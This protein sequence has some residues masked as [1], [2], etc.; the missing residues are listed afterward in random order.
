MIK[1]TKTY[2]LQ[3]GIIY[4]LKK[5]LIVINDIYLYDTRLICFGISLT[6]MLYLRESSQ[7]ENFVKST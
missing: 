7:L 2:F 3:H 5:I 6:Q 1:F 4:R